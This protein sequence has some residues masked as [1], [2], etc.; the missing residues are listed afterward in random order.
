MRASFNFLRTYKLETPHSPVSLQALGANIPWAQ[1]GV[2]QK[3]NVGISGYTS[4]YAGEG[5]Q[6]SPQT[7]EFQ[8]D[9]SHASGRHF[10]RFGTG[11]RHTRE[12][13]WNRTSDEGNPTFN[14]QRTNLSSIKNS[15]DS[16]ASFLLGLP[17][18]FS[19]ASTTQQNLVQTSFD[20][21]IQD[22]W[23]ISR[24]LT[25]NLGLRWEPYLPCHDTMG[26]LAGFL[27]GVKSTIIPL[28][29]AGLV[30]SGDPTIPASVIHSYWRQ[31]SPRFGFAWDVSGDGKTVIRGGYGIFRSGAEFFG[32]QR[33]VATTAPTRTASISIPNPPSFANPFAGYQGPIPFP[34]QAPTQAQLASYVYPTNSALRALD[35]AT[36]PGYSQNWN[37]TVERQVFKDTA[38]TISYVGNHFLNNLSRYNANP[39]LYGPGASTSNT[40]SRRLYP[41]F[42]GITLGASISHGNY[43][44][45]QTQITKRAA[46]GLTILANYT[47]SKAMDID[48]TGAFGAALG[49]APKDPFNFKL[50]TGPAD[51]DLTHQAKIAAIYD[52]P[53]LNRGPS[54]LL[55][56]ANGW[57][58]NSMVLARTGYPF[59]CQSGVDNSL[60]NVGNDTCDQIDPQSSRPAGANP[61][62]MWFNTSAFA[63][64]AIGTFGNSGRNALRQ[65]GTVNV[66]ASAFRMFRVT[67]KVQA[68]F[69]VEAFNAFNHASL[70]LFKITNAYS[71]AQTRTSPTFGKITAAMDPRLMQV[72]LK[73]R[74]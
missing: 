72:A 21:W 30:L 15:G 51:F 46:R 37:F 11:V 9:F 53:K 48:S 42:A 65:P 10:L 29:P 63:A 43:H 18:N 57:Q 31:L 59:T 71:S 17:S 39:A 25:F 68:E 14:A 13:T 1:P 16:F 49:A 62:Q 4:V 45:L 50:S 60:S 64:N 34:F 52:L 12:N 66:N 33:Q 69:R 3:I 70:R 41:G 61:M 28:A 6:F 74:F 35:P 36:R 40:N 58:I 44:G 32:M 38:V 20:P 8:L 2:P 7:E 26:P 27:P 54:A 55:H 56:A 19:E 47:W 67:E 22:D 73:L 23:K 24:H 5:Y